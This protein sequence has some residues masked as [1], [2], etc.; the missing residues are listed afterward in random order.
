MLFAQ[1]YAKQ[2][3]VCLFG[4]GLGTD[5]LEAVF[6]ISVSISVR[7]TKWLCIVARFFSELKW[8]IPNT[9]LNLWKKCIISLQ[10]ALSP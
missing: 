1:T 10:K 8:F 4:G 6:T 9:A 7:S 5:L 3:I 2:H